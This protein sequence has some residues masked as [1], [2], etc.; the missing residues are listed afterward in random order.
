MS[1]VKRL[2]NNSLLKDAGIYTG[3]AVSDRLLPFILLPIITRYLGPVEYGIYATFQ[4][5]IAFFLPY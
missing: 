5:L 2:L 3:F 4:A 1:I